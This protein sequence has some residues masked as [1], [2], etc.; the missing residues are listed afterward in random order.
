MAWSTTRFNLSHGGPTEFVDGVW[1]SGRYFEVLGVPAILGRT[2]TAA[3]DRRGGG[4]DGAVAVISYAF[5]Q[6]R[7]GG[8]ADVVG[9][10]LQ[11]ERVPFTI[12]GVTP[13]GFFGVDVGRTFDVA[14]PTRHR[15]AHPRQGER[16]RSAVELVA[17]HHGPAEGRSVGRS[18]AGCVARRATTGP[19]SHDAAGLARGRQTKLH[20]GRVHA[21][22]GRHGQLR[23]ARTLSATAHH[24]DGR[25]RPRAAHRMREHRE[26]P[27]GAGDSPA[28]R[29]ECPSCARRLAR[30]SGAPAA[31]REPRALGSRRDPWPG[32]RAVV[33]P[34]PG[35]PTVD[36]D[37]ERTPG[38][39]PRLASARVHRSG[40]HR[41]GS[42]LR[43]RSS[44]SC[45]ARCAERR[46]EGAGARDCRPE[47]VRARQPA[48]GRPGRTVDGAAGRRGTLHAHVRVARQ[49]RLGIRPRACARCR[50][51]RPAPATRTRR[52]PGPAHSAARRRR[53]HA[54]SAARG[55]FR[56]D[57]NQRQHLVLPTGPPGWQTDGGGRQGNLR[58][59]GQ[60][61]LVQ[62][63]RHADARR[64]RL[65]RRRQAR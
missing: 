30:A 14:I 54:W 64:P 23:V 3:D 26:P 56:G 39:V 55:A 42:D 25:C 53:H 51:E 57:A 28:A 31:R 32:V 47:P 15:A 59:S 63:L 44:H 7:F 24:A 10:S 20:A 60:P 58:Q 21:E 27:P 22:S 43:H 16:A 12:V 61:G 19:R 52:A 9:R 46:D 18:R 37:A 1:A 8:A 62:D 35:S 4:P 17:E 49:S 41:H 5:W 11:I 45:H 40:G 6:R 34:P 13:P 48:G 29:A 36:D 50:S 2:W 38:V 65:H 33:Q